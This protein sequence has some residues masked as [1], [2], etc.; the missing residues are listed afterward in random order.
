MP[1]RCEYRPDPSVPAPVGEGDVGD[2]T[3]VGAGE[4]VD[5]VQPLYVHQAD[6]AVVGGGEGGRQVGREV[7]GVQDIIVVE[8]VTERGQC[9]LERSF[10]Y[11]V[12]R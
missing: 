4:G 6:L 7:E 5:G 2:E 3:A 8:G 10:M 11:R 9:V 12:I 1:C